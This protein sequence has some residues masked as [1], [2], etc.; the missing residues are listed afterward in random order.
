MTGPR[1]TWLFEFQGGSAWSLPG[2]LVIE[3]EGRSGWNLHAHWSTRPFEGGQLRPGNLAVHALLGA[4]HR[5]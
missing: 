1:A 4:G 2:P 3:R 5:W